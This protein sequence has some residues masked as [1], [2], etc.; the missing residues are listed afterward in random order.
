MS[1]ENAAPT[2]RLCYTCRSENWSCAKENHGLH[3]SGWSTPAKVAGNKS[4]RSSKE[5]AVRG[6]AAQIL[7]FR[8]SGLADSVRAE[9]ILPA[10]KAS[11]ITGDGTHLVIATFRISSS[12]KI[13]EDVRVSL[14]PTTTAQELRE[15]LEDMV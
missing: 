6:G 9:R 12:L 4:R 13:Q 15:A 3:C 10:S 2:P 1:C 14:C 5:D 7:D 11:N 8:K